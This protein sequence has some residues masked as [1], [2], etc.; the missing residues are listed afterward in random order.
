MEVP[1]AKSCDDTGELETVAPDIR[2]L[3]VKEDLKA[4]KQGAALLLSTLKP[5]QLAREGSRGACS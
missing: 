4:K 5:E 2:E 1:L 3:P